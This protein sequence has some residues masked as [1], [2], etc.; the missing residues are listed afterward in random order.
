M[1]LIYDNYIFDLDGT[2]INS[3]K[4][5]LLCL[6]K[7]F[8]KSDYNINENNLT[9]NLI[10]PPIKQ[11]VQ[12]IAPELQN[13]DKI[14]EIISNFRYFY[15]NE[16]NDISEIYPYV[17]ETLEYLKSFNKKM[18]IATFKPKKSTM[19]IIKQFNLNYFDDIYTIDKFDRHITKEEMIGDII[20]N[21]NLN[22]S[23][24]V[25]VGDAKT[26]MTA[27]KSCGITAIGALWGYGDD[28]QPLIESADITIRGIKELWD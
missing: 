20:Y 10:G 1:S 26:D 16:Q 19:R 3:S 25:M 15:D 22:K 8:E 9:S 27:A 24:T 6:K 5:V 7:A 17:H 12:A 4:E 28:K 18:F 23:D 21:Y 2:I 14:S 11:I 13:E